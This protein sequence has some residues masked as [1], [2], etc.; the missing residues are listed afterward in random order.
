LQFG[1]VFLCDFLRFFL[2]GLLVYLHHIDFFRFFDLKI[3]FLNKKHPIWFFNSVVE[4]W[5]DL[6]RVTF[7]YFIF[8]K[9][10]ETDNMLSVLFSNKK[11]KGS[12]A[13]AWLA[14]PDLFF[15]LIL[16]Y[17]YIFMC[18]LFELN[19]LF[20]FKLILLFIWFIRLCISSFLNSGFFNYFVRI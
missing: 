1:F 10:L 20:I 6:R 12:W 7:F 11:I 15:F 16:F 13:Q 8:L 17:W 4:N 3:I 18:F 19:F 5:E 9:K 14:R 2:I